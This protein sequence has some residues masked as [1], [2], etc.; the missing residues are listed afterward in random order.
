MADYEQALVRF[1]RGAGRIRGRLTRAY[2]HP[3]ETVWAHITDSEKLA[4]WLAP[5]SIQLH[6]GG[7]AK[8]NFVNSGV[9]VDSP[10]TLAEP[11][12]RLCYSW[13]AENEPVRPLDWSLEELEGDTLLTL[14]VSLPEDEDAGRACAGWESHLE[15]LAA[16]LEG[17]TTR[18]PTELF[19]S[20]RDAYR[21]QLAGGA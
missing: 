14:E 13:S 16:A 20:R 6:A 8:L 21:A 11:P 4:Q 7:A 3:V 2:A 1:E 10:V 5:G 9:I 17:V 15:M 18:F 12:R 19:L